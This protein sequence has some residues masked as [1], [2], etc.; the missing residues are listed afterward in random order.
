MLQTPYIR[1]AT[2]VS[3]ILKKKSVLLLGPRR[4]GKSSLLRN[5]IQPDKVY[6][7]LDSNTFRELATRPALIRE[8][9]KKTDRLIVIDE[10]QKLPNLMDEIHLMIEDLGVHFLL[11]G[12]SARK[13]KRSHSS[14]MAGRARRQLLF[15]FSAFE[16]GK[17]FD[18]ER[19]LLYGTL[20]P[21][22]LSD[23][24]WN[25]LK[26]YVG[27]YLK[28]EIMAEALSRNI[29]SF[30]RFLQTAAFSNAEILNFEKIGADA[31]VPARTI[32]EYYSVLEDTLLGSSVEPLQVKKGRK[33]VSKSKFYFFDLGVLNSLLDRQTLSPKTPEFGNLF[34]SWVYLEL[35]TYLSYRG[36]DESICFWRT[37]L[38]QE[39]DFVING[40]VGIE[41]K[42][43]Q[44]VAER[45]LQGLLALESETKLKE[46]FVISRDR[47]PRTV[48]GVEILPYAVFI[49][50]L[51]AGELI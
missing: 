46:K 12:S 2:Q 1:R 17:S 14:L 9:L 44:Q 20:P 28:E 26:S 47:E 7:L 34:E 18:L 13:L 30:A 22:Y 50:R 3:E 48:S 5:E 42:S 4:T 49:E 37:N 51:W 25:E 21:V 45:D 35:R 27:D 41:V 24:P 19:A 10:I 32:R 43:T 39:V 29:E 36:R 6:N 40:S 33:T 11:T 15:G 23:D 16:L 31:Q 38:G 8:R